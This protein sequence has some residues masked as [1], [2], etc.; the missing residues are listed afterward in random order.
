MAT[1]KNDESLPSALPPVDLARLRLARQADGRYRAHWDGHS[2]L[3]QVISC[4]PWTAPGAYI[5]LRD[6][7]DREVA[8]V[9]S[10]AD[11]D[12]DSAA[13][14]QQALRESAFAFQITGVQQV[15]KAFEIRHWEV[16]CAEG[17][18]RFQTK[19]DDFPE[20]LAPHGLLITDVAGDV[21]VVPDWTALDKRSRKQLALFVG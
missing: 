18:R 13:V 8:L 6:V 17:P 12:P 7:H 19:V 9:P 16:T 3:V 11:L 10:L 1:N 5:S 21:Y 14:L 2:V 4:F 15:R 20:A